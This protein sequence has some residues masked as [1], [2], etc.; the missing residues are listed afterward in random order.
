M[1]FRQTNQLRTKKKDLQENISELPKSIATAQSLIDEIFSIFDSIGKNLVNLAMFNV[2]PDILDKFDRDFKS[3]GSKKAEISSI[4]NDINRFSSSLKETDFGSSDGSAIN[5][6]VI[7]DLQTILTN[8]NETIGS[9]ISTKLE[10]LKVLKNELTSINT[11]VK[12]PVDQ[13]NESLQVFQKTTDVS[14]EIFTKSMLESLKNSVE[15]RS[16]TENLESML[17]DLEDLT[18][19]VPASVQQ[20]LKEEIRSVVNE[21]ISNFDSR[22]QKALDEKLRDIKN[23]INADLSSMIDQKFEHLLDQ[24]AQ[25]QPEPARK[26]MKT[27]EPGSRDMREINMFLKYLY[28]WPTGKDDIIKKIE[29]FRDTLLVKRTD[30][31]PFRVTAT[32]IFREAISELSRE[33]RHISQDKLRE[34]VQLFENLKRTIES[35]EG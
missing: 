30:D 16:I 6:T 19:K 18:K 14:F 23:T 15:M 26:E 3:Y 20:S 21:G 7:D 13:I 28:E 1:A 10:E 25:R 34:I 22:I 4:L 12:Q 31:P 9:D 11:Q 29:D 35:T 5:E 33:D 24:L 17:F 8:I 32:N 2:D 27:D